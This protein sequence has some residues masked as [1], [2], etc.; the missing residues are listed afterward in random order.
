MGMIAASVWVLPAMR[1]NEGSY[2]RLD[3]L[4]LPSAAPRALVGITRHHHRVT[5]AHH[6]GTYRTTI[7]EQSCNG[8][9]VAISRVTLDAYF[10]TNH[11]LPEVITGSNGSVY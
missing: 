8:S 6:L 2:L 4:A 3:A 9:A 1:A 7:D 10:A 5:T 11:H